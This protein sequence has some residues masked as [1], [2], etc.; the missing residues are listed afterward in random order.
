VPAN[1]CI[2]FY[3]DGDEVTVHAV[4]ALT[5]KRFVRVT[6]RQTGYR[7]GTGVNANLDTSGIGG[8]YLGDVPAGA[9]ACLGVAQYDVAAGDK[10]TV[11]R[12]KILPVTAGATVTVGSLVQVDSA[13]RVINL[14]SGVAVGLCLVGATIGNDA[15]ILVY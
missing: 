3:D 11:M 13:G 4:N 7:A 10:V 2:P 6:G 1:E 9:E 15:E 8:N 12:R 14:A 5:G